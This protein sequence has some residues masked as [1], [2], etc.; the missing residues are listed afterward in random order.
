MS[1]T[2]F[3]HV[4]L[5]KTASS[6]FQE[7]CA[8][9]S[10]LLASLGFDYPLFKCEAANKNKIANHSIPL[11]SLFTEKPKKYHVNAK[12]GIQ[13]S[14]KEV[15]SSYEKQL[16]IHLQN[17]NNLVISGEDI[18]VLSRNSILKLINK[19]H[20]YNFKIKACAIVRSP[21]SALCSALQQRIKEG[22]FIELISLDDTSPSSFN[23][24]PF[25]TASHLRKMRDIFGNRISFY[26]FDDACSHIYGPAAFLVQE[27]LNQD[28]CDFEYRRTNESRSNFFI[29]IQNE[30]NKTNP[31]FVNG[32]SNPQF[33]RIPAKIDKSFRYTGKFL[34]TKV[35]HKLI[36][37]FIA[38]E[39]HELQA[40]TGINFKSNAFK[41]SKPIFYP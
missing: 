9:N 21:Y 19:L 15:N 29:R 2:C 35:E 32:R 25:K 12:W 22:E 4:G 36:E 41:F 28:P 34:L 24:Q 31:A 33:Q 14:I 37:D 11:F 6:S 5:H 27:F 16:E 10:R 40:I 30:F 23:P 8:Q 1:K 20:Q 18:S 38:E 26:D 13:E 3:L 7:T 39:A 17:S